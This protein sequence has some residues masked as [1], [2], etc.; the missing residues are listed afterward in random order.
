LAALTRGDLDLRAVEALAE[1]T[2][3]VD[4]YTARAMETAVLPNAGRWNLT[5]LRRAARR[6][7][8][9]LDPAGAEQRHAARRRVEL[10]PADDVK[11][12][13][14]TT[15]DRGRPAAGQVRTS[16]TA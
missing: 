15:F 8:A 10:F 11:G 1:I 2:D 12:A 4:A 5:E 9:R 3:P 13:S 6:A 16:Q 7:V 14:P